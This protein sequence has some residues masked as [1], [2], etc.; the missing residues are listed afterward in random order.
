MSQTRSGTVYKATQTEA[1]WAA[2]KAQYDIRGIEELARAYLLILQAVDAG[3][4]GGNS[5]NK[6]VLESANILREVLDDEVETY[7]DLVDFTI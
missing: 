5:Y 3:F 1:Q 6:D 7:L 2:D 4:P